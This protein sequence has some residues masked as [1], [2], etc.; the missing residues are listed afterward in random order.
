[1]IFNQARANRKQHKSDVRRSLGNDRDLVVSSFPKRPPDDHYPVS[2][3][4]GGEQSI[5]RA[6]LTMIFHV[7]IS[8]LACSVV[9]SA[10]LKK[11]AC[12]NDVKGTGIKADRA[13]VL[14]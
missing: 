5:Y 9:Q 2:A 10:R 11:D 3:F 7:H 12:P 4:S 13:F 8:S 1:M 6:S 14:G